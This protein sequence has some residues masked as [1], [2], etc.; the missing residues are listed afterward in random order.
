MRNVLIVVA[1]VEQFSDI[2]QFFGSHAVSISQE[3][4]TE[5][6]HKL[7]DNKRFGGV[8][9]HGNNDDVRDRFQ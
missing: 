1:F 3:F 8:D 5:D 9:V 6:P 4:Q 7:D 2:F